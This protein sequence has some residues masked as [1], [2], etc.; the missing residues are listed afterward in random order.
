MQPPVEGHILQTKTDLTFVNREMGD[1]PA[2]LG[3]I[4]DQY[5]DPADAF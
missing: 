1:R 4:C 5:D 2:S 3:V